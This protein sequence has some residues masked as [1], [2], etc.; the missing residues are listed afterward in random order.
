MVRLVSPRQSS[1]LSS[2]SGS[3]DDND[4][5]RVCD[6]DKDVDDRL[7]FVRNGTTVIEVVFL[8]DFAE[9]FLTQT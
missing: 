4:T 7:F 8:V 1:K 9:S 5:T 6:E 3:E 2:G